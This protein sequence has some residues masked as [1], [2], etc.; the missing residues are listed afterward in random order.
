[1][2]YELI[3]R[4]PDDQP[5]GLRPISDAVF[6]RAAISSFSGGKPTIPAGSTIEIDRG[7]ELTRGGTKH[8]FV[9]RKW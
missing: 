4:T 7:G 2:G 3:Y 9:M 1:M 8:S 6:S 5:T